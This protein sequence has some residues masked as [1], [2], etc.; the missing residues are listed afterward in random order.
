MTNEHY[1]QTVDAQQRAAAPK[2][3]AFVSA[4][5]GSGKTRVLTN[6]VTRLLLNG[7]R[8]D[9]ILCITFTKAAAAEMSERLF[10]QLGPWALMEDK[11][12]RESL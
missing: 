1:K 6:R 8:P 5:A 12:L 3:S 2:Q 11:D 4:N 10:A 9:R 7:A